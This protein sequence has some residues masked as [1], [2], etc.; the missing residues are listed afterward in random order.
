MRLDGTQ[1]R[2]LTE[3]CV[4]R[5]DGTQRRLLTEDGCSPR[6]S[7]DGRWIVYSR[8]LKGS[9][10]SSLR[11]VDV[12]GR[13]DR[14]LFCREGLVLWSH[15][16]SPDGRHVAVA[17]CDAEK[18]PGGG[19]RLTAGDAEAQ[20]WRIAIVD[21]SNSQNLRELRLRGVRT[22]HIGSLDWR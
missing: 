12:D 22:F 3:V 10:S 17:M 11:M 16:W 9:L 14:E 7:P 19:M 4:M 13:N 5:L 2:L 21:V 15:C 18:L 1:R 6:F 8:Q 20:D